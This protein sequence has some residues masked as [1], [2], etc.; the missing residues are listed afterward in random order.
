MADPARKRSLQER[1]GA[2]RGWLLGQFTL[3]SLALI[4]G[5]LGASTRMRWAAPWSRPGAIAAGLLLVGAGL[6]IANKA[7]A[8]L[9]DSLRVAPTPLEHA[10]LVEDGWYGRVRH[11]LYLA[12]LLCVAGWALIW[13]N[14]LVFVMLI[15]IGG[16]LQLKARHEERLLSATYSGYRAYMRRVRSRFVPRVW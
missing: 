9:G 3:L 12:V 4:A 8:D 1:I 13:M 10:R 6:T 7:R 2:D 5:P 11:P 14:A 16:F 15:A